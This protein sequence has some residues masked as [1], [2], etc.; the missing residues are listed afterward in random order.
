ML[1]AIFDSLDDA[2]HSL[3]SVGSAVAGTQV[4]LI[5]DIPDVPR[6]DASG[7]EPTA[8]MCGRCFADNVPLFPAKCAEKPELHTNLGMY[9]CPDCGA[10]LM[11]GIPHF[12]MCQLCID[13]QHPSYD[14]ASPALHIEVAPTGFSL[15]RQLGT[16][17][18]RV[19]SKLENDPDRLSVIA[20]HALEDVRIGHTILIPMTQIAA[21]NA[22]SEAINTL[23]AGIVAYPLHGGLGYDEQHATLER[24]LEG[25]VKILVVSAG[26]LTADLFI[27]QASC[28]YD[29]TLFANPDPYKRR[30]NSLF[31]RHEGKK[32]P[33]LRLFLDDLNVRRR[34]LQA[35]LNAIEQQWSV[36]MR[37]QTGA[38]LA[39]YFPTR[40]S[41][42]HST[43]TMD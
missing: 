9:H 6:R 30:L 11:G 13:Q 39:A 27:P 3:F 32:E 21:I 41:A 14:A 25:K 36:I 37:P 43:Q 4:D 26:M 34:C 38:T 22:L 42:C 35:Q 40:G 15:A 20:E 29:V 33:M 18:V 7:D 2:F 16:P 5:D 23:V 31:L 24:M 12:D 8:P 10:M 19:L 1:S 28:L 17:W